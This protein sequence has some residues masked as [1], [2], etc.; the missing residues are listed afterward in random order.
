MITRQSWLVYSGLALALVLQS[1]ASAHAQGRGKT[2]LDAEFRD[3]YDVGARAAPALRPAP[4]PAPAT[5]PA[6]PT[7]VV[8]PAPVRQA[9]DGEKPA[10]ISAHGHSEVAA[11]AGGTE[12]S[13]P[14]PA[15]ELEATR[16]RVQS[17]WHGA[18]GGLHLVDANS[19]LPGSVRL[20]LGFDYFR[21]H[22]F[23]LPVD[24]DENLGGTL[25]LSVSPIDHLEIFGSLANH[26][27]S[28]SQST[29]MLLQVV[30]DLL[31]G[32]KGY[33]TVLPWLDLGGDLRL[34]F[35]NTIGDMGLVFSGT[36]LGLRGDATADL[37]RIAHPVPLIFR[38]NL[39]YFFDNS[40]QLVRGVEDAR[41]A[42]LSPTTRRV[43][44]TED[45]NLITSVERFG[46]G[47]NRVDM[48]T[49]GFGVEAPLQAATDFYVQPLLEWRLGLPVNR[50]GYNCLAV[51]TSGRIGQPDGCLA[52]QGIAAAPSTLSLGARVLPPLPG[53]SLL[54]G[55]DIGV[56]G[57]SS[58]VRE[59]A[60]TR[61]WAFLF[62]LGYGADVRKPKPEV[63][64]VHF[65]AVARAK[66]AAPKARVQGA[67]V[68]QGENIA[69][70]FAV[71]RYPGKDLS[72]QLSSEDGRFISY[73][74]DPGT[75]SFE[76]SHP[77]FEPRTCTVEIAVPYFQPPSAAQGNVAQAPGR[78]SA[79]AP[80]GLPRGAPETQASAVGIGALVPLRCEL[81]RRAR[82]GRVLGQLFAETG[83]PLASAQLAITGPA[84]RTLSADA[85]G[86]FSLEG[87]PAGQYSARAELSGYLVK[88]EPFTVVPGSDTTLQ[89]TLVGKPKES[90]VTMTSH[91]V[92]IRK[93]IMFTP[94]A[95]QIDESSTALLSEIADVL[96]RNAQVKQVQVQ[97]H[98]DNR[99]DPAQNLQLSQARAEAVVAWLVHA[100]VA[101]D[102]LEAKGYGDTHPVVP[103][104]T[105]GN[106][107]RNRRVQFI[108]KE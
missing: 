93:Q 25:S 42:A 16:V 26:A 2:S 64:I 44:A 19:G 45:R 39:D 97:G 51:V 69:I 6:Q 52:I 61:P 59:L 29:P 88:Q 33:A 40:A 62:T 90:Q 98:T 78:A 70:G 82:A 21:G 100:G 106:R 87:L 3:E 1:A 23:L 57:T 22:R 96:V 20:Q 30:G 11:D 53:L 9:R 71:V 103:N 34:V 60:P 31:L 63:R 91:E 107:A 17:S 32:A 108:I 24:T 27:N 89:I 83:A 58:F 80:V 76:I 72:A 49:F 5:Q 105:P 75:V 18:A 12:S 104:L 15:A 13:P 65:P 8:Q 67:V 55:L 94:G 35:L 56:S 102:R 43:R 84:E 74:L 47:I 38:T 36:S 77:D 7:P 41:Y 48:L 54:I 14:P 66:P 92:K 4:A 95:A 79:L 85:Q 46:L 73:E 68:A 50:Q 28:N 99:G 81:T 37:R 86:R 10:A 101:A